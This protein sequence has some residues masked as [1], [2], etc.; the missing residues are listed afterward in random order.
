[1]TPEQQLEALKKVQAQAEQ[2]VKLGMQLFKAAEARINAQQDLVDQFHREQDALRDQVQQD[3]AKTL[4]EYD[5]WVGRIDES[6]THAIERLEQRMSAIEQ[7]VAD[8]KGEIRSAVARAEEML[9]QTRYLLDHARRPQGQAQSAAPPEST[10]RE[11][12]PPESAPSEAP[13]PPPAPPAAATS[14]KAVPPREAAPPAEAATRP[15]RPASP[16][17]R[18]APEPGRPLPPAEPA[19]DDSPAM[20][21]TDQEKVYSRLLDQLRRH[22]EEGPS[23]EA[24]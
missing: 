18:V 24:A 9:D 4:Q 19:A 22:A 13:P 15:A 5:Q 20:T 17:G 10:P 7:S 3:V 23:S 12:A 14:G 1:M 8:S 16:P 21:S 6:F 2:R 11:S